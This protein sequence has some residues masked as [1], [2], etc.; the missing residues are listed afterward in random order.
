MGEEA[1][2]RHVHYMTLTVVYSSG[3]K[4]TLFFP[5]A[6]KRKS[7]PLAFVVNNEK[8]LAYLKHQL[9]KIKLISRE[10]Y[11]NEN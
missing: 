6:P 4:I 1:I 11:M 7:C 3:R 2:L 9:Q 8:M 10:Y 5:Y